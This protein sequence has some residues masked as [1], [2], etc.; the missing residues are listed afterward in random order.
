MIASLQWRIDTHHDG[1]MFL[2]AILGKSNNLPQDSVFYFYGIAQPLF[3]GLIFKFLPIS[4]INYRLIAFALIMLTGYFLYKIISLK[5]SK[6]ISLVFSL[7]WMFANPTWANSFESVPVSIQTPWPN[8]WIQTFFI[9]CVYIIL[10]SKLETFSSLLLVSTMAGSMPF[11][12][13]QGMVYSFYVFILVLIVNKTRLLRYTIFSIVVIFA[14]LTLIQ[15][16]GGLKLYLSN[17]IFY[18]RNFYSTFT[19]HDYVLDFFIH[20]ITYYFVC[21]AL[22]IS[23]LCI[24]NI[25][26]IKTYFWRKFLFLNLCL[27]AICAAIQFEFNQWLEI[28]I[29]NS[30]SIILDS[31]LLLAV[32]FAIIIFATDYRARNRS[33]LS[34]KT[35][36]G[37]YSLASVSNLFFQFPLPD[38]GHRWW[39]S[40]ILVLFIAEATTIDMYQKFKLQQNLIKKTIVMGCIASIFFS[41]LQGIKFLSFERSELV[42]SGTN[43]YNGIKIPKRDKE[44]IEKFNS[45]LKTLRYLE[46]LGVKINYNCR[47]GLYYL[48]DSN[49]VIESKNFL[50]SPGK[51][52]E[53]LQYV[54]SVESKVTFYC[55]VDSENIKNLSLFKYFVIG[56]NQTDLFVVNDSYIYQKLNDFF[57]YEDFS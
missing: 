28:I 20:S 44:T 41:G 54:N 42:V 21:A 23:Y 47:D 9:S 52:R 8:L 12:R 14:W 27:L 11:F 33:D 13:M 56:S 16:H 6:T 19:S 32:I 53:V 30:S 38:L 51:E 57:E 10:R 46:N 7:T 3:E 37:F 15:F 36:L 50:Y 39:S 22:L 40:A 43:I 45:S 1:I 2:P 24:S 5:L 29:K 31:F 18:P 48:R 55:N 49:Y 17:T 34:T 4:I 35:I 26:Y 25:T